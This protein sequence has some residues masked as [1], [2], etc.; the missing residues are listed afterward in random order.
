MSCVISWQE[1]F[2]SPYICRNFAKAEKLQM[3]VIRY[4]LYHFLNRDIW[5]IIPYFRQLEFNILL[6][7]FCL[8]CSIC[9]IHVINSFPL[10][11]VLEKLS[12]L[13]C[14]ELSRSSQNSVLWEWASIFHVN[15]TA[16][17]YFSYQSLKNDEQ[18]AKT[19][20]QK[21]LEL[22]QKQR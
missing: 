12:G 13:V 21:L 9:T 11:L 14:G 20:V 3:K 19:D 7:P 10:S 1:G 6:N 15:K 2:L 8:L 22:G 18:S 4:I 16:F 17:S 5:G